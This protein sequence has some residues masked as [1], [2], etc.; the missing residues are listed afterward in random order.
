[1]THV[2]A[3][4]GAR[5]A[6]FHRDGHGG[7]GSVYGAGGY[8]LYPVTGYLGDA[9]ADGATDDAGEE[10]AQD[11]SA[12]PVSEYPEQENAYAV[13]RQRVIAREPMAENAEAT[14]VEPARETQQYVFVKRDGTLFFAVGYS[15]EKET[16][17]YVTKE[18]L[19]RSVGRDAIDMNATQQFNEQRGLSF[20][21][22]A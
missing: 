4:R 8:V 16:L 2:A 12:G 21:V 1:M 18:G 13:D 20:R 14:P 19:R 10:V 3:T 15:W 17:W 9:V 7:R 5:G 11:Q 22:P 6:G